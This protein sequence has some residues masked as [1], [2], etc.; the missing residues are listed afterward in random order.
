[1]F[2]IIMPV[3]NRAH[4][5]ERAI[6]SILAQTFKDYELIIV[7]DGS[8]DNLKSIIQPYLSKNIKYYK[9]RHS[10][11]NATRNYGIEHSKGE[12][13]AYLDSDNLWHPDFL[14]EMHKALTNGVNIR[15]AAYCKYNIYLKDQSTGKVHLIGIRGE[16]FYLEEFFQKICIDINAFVHSKRI[17]KE[18]GLFDT[19]LK[20][21]TDWDFILRIIS[22]YKPVSVQKVLVD[23]YIGLIRN[24][25]T[26]KEDAMKAYK[27]L[28]K[29]YRMQV[30][31]EHDTI[32][33]IWDFVP[34]K[35]YANYIAMSNQKLDTTNFTTPGFP[36]MLQIEPTNMCNL[37]CPLCPAGRNELN[38]K[39]QNMKF[40]TF[41]SLIDNMRK[42]LL[43]LIMW[44]WGEPFMN[45]ELPDM[46]EYASRMGIK[47]VVS[48]NAHF[49]QDNKYIK[50]I[51]K[52]GLT[53]LIIAIDSIKENTYKIYRKRGN[54]NKVLS[55][56]KNVLRLKKE[57]KSNTFINFRMVIMKQN[58]HEL[59]MMR[60][61]ARTL[62]VDRFSVK[63]VNPSCGFH[64]MDKDY[65][66]KNPRYRRYKYRKNTFERI[67]I[68]PL[69]ISPWVK[70]NILSNG[71]VVPCC[72]DYNAELKVGNI[73]E[74]PYSQI[75]MSDSYRNLRR[76]IHVNKNTIPKCKECTLNFKL[77]RKGWFLEYYDFNSSFKNELIKNINVV[78]NNFPL[79]QKI[80]TPIS[81]LL[82]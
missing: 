68:N 57:L 2:S 55:G 77:S 52:S 10:G 6:N 49:L 9:K 13:I 50:R 32:Q 17:I 28:K 12:F 62:R 67:R 48:T 19:R 25:I 20:R 31:I 33:Y 60:R 1:M 81:R 18:V 22:R 21:F 7:D 39:P 71:D 53:T 58:E 3:W 38:R 51:L 65:V 34:Y 4:I 59:E 35:K 61:L 41:K 36:F 56:L 72:Y 80:K 74:K 82:Y 46:L 44:D 79:I 47:T 29:K 66:P 37:K 26:F 75:W 76:R 78:I 43:F 24:T 8:K 40:K 63:T 15:N 69:C 64:H 27:L 5:V 14:F 45:P 23:Y 30:K 73:N 42:Y 54:L 70:S 16:K 11:L